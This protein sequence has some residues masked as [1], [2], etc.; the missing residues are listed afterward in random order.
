MGRARTLSVQQ[1]PSIQPC[2]AQLSLDWCR[3]AT[4]HTERAGGRDNT[5]G[6]LFKAADITFSRSKS[7]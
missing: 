7:K 6:C 1:Q 4:V 2:T 5:S 3:K